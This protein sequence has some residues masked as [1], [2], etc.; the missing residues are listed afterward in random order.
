MNT[1]CERQW[2]ASDEM[3][4]AKYQE[5]GL[6]GVYRFLGPAGTCVMRAETKRW[7]GKNMV[8]DEDFPVL[9]YFCQTERFGS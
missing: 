9:R 1:S 3:R 8:H 6:A 5:I 2:R 7:N 4:C